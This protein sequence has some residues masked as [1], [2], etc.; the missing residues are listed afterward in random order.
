MIAAV[1]TNESP[2]YCYE[3]ARRNIPECCQLDT[4]CLKSLKSQLGTDFT[5]QELV[6]LRIKQTQR[7]KLWLNI[8]WDLENVLHHKRKNRNFKECVRK[9]FCVPLWLMID[10]FILLSIHTTNN[11]VIDY[12]LLVYNLLPVSDFIDPSSGRFG[13]Y[14]IQIN[15]KNCI[16]IYACLDTMYSPL[17]IC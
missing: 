1:S 16:T 5:K 17:T 8:S 4:R 13:P 11:W 3:T 9:Y 6:E 12:L 2:V 15:Y 10:L 7:Y 14:Y